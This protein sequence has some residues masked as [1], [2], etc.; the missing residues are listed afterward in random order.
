MAAG[1]D[2]AVTAHVAV[3]VAVAADTA[4]V[5]AVA[6]IGSVVEVGVANVYH[7]TAAAMKS[8]EQAKVPVVH[9]Y[10]YQ[11]LPKHA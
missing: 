7:W 1:V 10:Y 8:R 11:V 6:L 3:A 4:T 9:Q 5:I 2:T